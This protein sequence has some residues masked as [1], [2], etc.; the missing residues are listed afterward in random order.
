MNKQPGGAA[1]APFIQTGLLRLAFS[2]RE[3]AAAPDS[4]CTKKLADRTSRE[5]ADV[6]ALARFWAPIG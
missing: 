4:D 1:K 5:G 3:A 6:Y 2:L